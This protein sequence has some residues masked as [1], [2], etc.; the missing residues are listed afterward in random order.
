MVWILKFESSA[1]F[2]FVMLDFLRSAR[3]L[4]PSVCSNRVRS[5]DKLIIIL[6]K[7]K[8][9]KSGFINN[10]ICYKALKEL[11]YSKKDLIYSKMYFIKSFRPK[12]M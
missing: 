3:I 5:W 11:I 1:S 7:I 8:M 10:M 9:V 4:L 6:P 2:S 12:G